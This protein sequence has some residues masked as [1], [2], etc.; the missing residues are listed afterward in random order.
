ME[1][2]ATGHVCGTTAARLRIRTGTENGRRSTER[3]Q[4]IAEARALAGEHEEARYSGSVWSGGGSLI[5]YNGS[6]R[7][8]C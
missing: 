8:S 2:A 7:R 1:R 4:A 6:G 3:W 5:C